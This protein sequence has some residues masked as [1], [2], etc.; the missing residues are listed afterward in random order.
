MIITDI[1]GRTY[2]I[3]PSEVAK[4]DWNDVLYNAKCITLR[5]QRIKKAMKGNGKKGMIFPVMDLSTLA[6]LVG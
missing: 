4:L 5:S 6:D 3:L 2:G 1:I